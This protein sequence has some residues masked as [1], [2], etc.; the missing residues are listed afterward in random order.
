M[1]FII[2]QEKFFKERLV[3][4]YVAKSLILV[5]SFL[6]FPMNRFEQSNI[7]SR[8]KTYIEIIDIL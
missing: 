3:I 1:K 7:L 6:I 5:K 2:E 4:L 8:Y